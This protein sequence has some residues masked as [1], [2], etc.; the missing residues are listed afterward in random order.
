MGEYKSE[1]PQPHGSFSA[2]IKDPPNRYHCSLSHEYCSIRS[3][4]KLKNTVQSK[5][6]TSI[7]TRG[8]VSDSKLF[9]TDALDPTSH[10]WK[11]SLKCTGAEPVS[12]LSSIALRRLLMGHDSLKPCLSAH[13][14]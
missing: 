6:N 5:E 8:T 4:L 11:N 1:L 7:S 2:R 12:F 3:D 13:A 9:A 10:I 14:P